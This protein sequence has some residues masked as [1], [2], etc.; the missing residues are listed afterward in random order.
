MSDLSL[1]LLGPLKITKNGTPVSNLATTKSQ[2]LLA[3][4]AVEAHQAQPRSLLANLLWPDQPERTALHN[5]RQ[6]L[7]TL[8]Q[9]IGDRHIEPPFLLITR[10]SLQFNLA[11]N[12]WLD[13][14]RFNQLLQAAHN[15]PIPSDATTI[16]TLQQASELYR[17]D[18]LNGLVIPD[19]D[20]F[21]AWLT[22][23]R[24]HYRREATQIQEQLSAQ[25]ETLSEY[26]A[27]ISHTRQLLELMPWQEAAHQRLMRCLAA[28]GQRNA[29]L[30]HY[31]TCRRILAEELAVEPMPDTTALFEKIRAG[32]WPPADQPTPAVIV[33]PGTASET[34]HHLP[35]QLTSFVGRQTDLAQLAEYLTDPACRLVTLVGPGG[36]GKT[37]LALQAAEQHRAHFADGVHFIP[38]ANINT[39]DLLPTA[40]GSILQLS[41]TDQPAQQTQLLAYLQTKQM[42]LVLDNFEHLRAKPNLIVDLLQAAPTLKLLITSRERLNLQA[43]WIFEVRG[44]PYPPP[45]LGRLQS[46]QPGLPEALATFGAVQLFIQRA[47]QV[48]PHF[49]LSPDSVPNLVQLCRLSEGLPLALELAAAQIRQYSL[50]EL[51]RVLHNK[52]DRLS[53]QQLDVPQRHR[54][55]RA[56]FNSAWQQLTLPERDLFSRLSI[57]PGSFSTD[58]AHTVAGSSL[59]DLINL[60]DKSMLHQTVPDRYEIHPLLRQFG[61][62]SLRQKREYD[63]TQDKHCAYYALF[64]KQREDPL[65]WGSHHQ[66]LDE[67][68]QEVENIRAGWQWAVDQKKLTELSQAHQGLFRLYQ[69]RNWLQEG[70]NV[71]ANAVE[72]LIG[73][74]NAWFVSQRQLKQQPSQP[75]VAA[76]ETVSPDW[77]DLKT[78]LLLSLA[79]FTYHIADYPTALSAA[80]A[81]AKLAIQRHNAI[82]ETRSYLVWGS[83][84]WHRGRHKIAKILFIQA[85]TLAH[86][87]GN[88]YLE[89]QSLQSL[90]NIY[91]Q[92]GRHVIAR[93]HY[94][95]ALVIYR[96]EDSQ[97]DEAQCLSQLGYIAGSRGDYATA[98]SYLRR[99]VNIYQHVG[100][101]HLEQE[102]LRILGL[103]QQN[104]G[105]YQ[106][107][108]R[109]FQQVANTAQ[110]FGNRNVTALA[111]ADLGLNT[112][113]LNNRKIAEKHCREALAIA[114][115]IKD[116]YSEGY[117][118][119]RLG[120]IL[121]HNDDLPAAAEAYRRAI[122]LRRKLG[123]DNIAVLD[124]AELAWVTMQ[125]KRR[126]QALTQVDEILT[127]L[128]SNDTT[129]FNELPRVY[130]RCYQVLMA[131][132]ATAPHMNLM[133]LGVLDATYNVLQNRADRIE[134]NRLRRSYLENVDIHRKITQAWQAENTHLSEPP[135]NN[136]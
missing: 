49:N 14:V 31:E 100:D 45:Q 50:D 94:K 108:Q 28:N 109:Y 95:R 4:L 15:P 116:R 1:H 11:S 91:R 118:Q 120:L 46:T 44:L 42:L 65:T 25:F 19:S 114:R 24:E 57:F 86:T 64:L 76:P 29:A 110:E 113:Y 131:A 115:D 10:Q 62:E 70:A 104:L 130:W 60:V 21:E 20:I 126:E 81:A 112:W 66:A 97:Q 26:G 33:A 59:A 18:F 98:Q 38:L 78:E 37:R 99:A 90:G 7:T 3:Y 41:F 17:G 117:S 68:V 79:Y 2:A 53:T 101:R 89:A 135:A 106:E 30:A 128:E 105:L 129:Y 16:N 51:V 23:N 80:Q 124:L 84:L 67:V 122:Y 71:F 96:A 82:N 61:L 56:L 111:L 87:N 136:L 73:P 6:A 47:K 36:I 107:A 43:E 13:V 93:E 74:P 39:A 5:L 32:Q 12:S 27:A 77:L 48:N 123:Q 85:L 69:L 83:A 72:T 40:L 92:R 54:N 119:S 121:A 52:L 75:D 9:A 8:R 63:A 125:R 127:W 55:L 22:T 58:A 134:N 34:L 102:P 133:R 88:A 132:N 103:I 35:A